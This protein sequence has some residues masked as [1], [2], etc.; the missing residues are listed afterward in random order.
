[1]YTNSIHSCT[2]DILFLESDGNVEEGKLHPDVLMDLQFILNRN[3]KAIIK[4]YGYY[5]NCLRVILQEKG[6]SPKELS[7]HLLSLSAFSAEHRLA[8]IADKDHKLEK[9]EAIIDVIVFLKKECSSF[10]DYE[11]FQEIA[12]KYNIREDREELRYGEYLTAYVNKHKVSEFIQVNPLLKSRDSSEKLTLKLDLQSTYRLAKVVELKESIA[13]V[14]KL[15]LTALQIVDL[16]KG[17]IV[18][19]FLI[20]AH[21]ADILFTTDTEFTPHQ[22]DQ[23]RALSILWIECNNLTF[24]F[25]K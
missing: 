21:V 5:V 9:A 22:V 20:P 24:H 13:E 25:R 15:N 14:F 4:R 23:F 6:V 17:C 16:N 1:M 18:V 12:T 8:L 7:D 10:L 3:L 2:F 19:T 11:I